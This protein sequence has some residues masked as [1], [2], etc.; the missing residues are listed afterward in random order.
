MISFLA[1][2][3]PHRK[4]MRGNGGAIE[5]TVLEIELRNRIPSHASLMNVSSPCRTERTATI[6]P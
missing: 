3:A 2:V 5:L 6:D 1:P 4:P